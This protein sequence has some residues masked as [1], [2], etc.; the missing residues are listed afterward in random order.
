M[1]KRGQNGDGCVS[2][3]TLFRYVCINGHLFVLS[4]ASNR[5]VFWVNLVSILRMG[6]G[7][8]LSNLLGVT[9]FANSYY[10]RFIFCY[11]YYSVVSIRF[12]SWFML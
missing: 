1:L 7:W 8:R 6:R 9:C 11:I 12:V 2:G 10:R 4:C 3:D 5:H